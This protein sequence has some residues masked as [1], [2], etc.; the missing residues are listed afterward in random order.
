MQL[1]YTLRRRLLQPATEQTHAMRHPTF[2]QPTSE[3][4]PNPEALPEALP[5]PTGWL[6][7][8]GSLLPLLL[9][10]ISLV[11]L[12]IC[13]VHA[14]RTRQDAWWFFIILFMP[15]FGPL[16]YLLAVL[17][18]SWKG[19]RVFTSA[20]KRTSSSYRREIKNLELR[21][22]QVDTV[23]TRSELGDACLKAG[24]F[25]KA[26]EYFLSCLQGNY[27]TNPYFWY[28]LAQ[29]C[30]EL[31]LYDEALNAI[32]KTMQA[33]YTDYKNDRV[34]LKAKTLAE[35]NRDEEAISLFQEVANFIPTQEGLCRLGIIL[36]R[37]NR[38][39]EAKQVFQKIL[40]SS[41]AMTPKTRKREKQWIDTAKKQL[42][43][44]A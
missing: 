26:R 35:L 19:E 22:S 12:V 20:A 5:E 28:G 42:Q 29:A 33:N 17:L 32:D 2:Y 8:V 9:S 13:L 11:L 21:L 37:N 14:I 43:K 34:L 1:F 38:T 31:G 16:V 41:Q 44:H 36:E 7:T 23:A 24:D 4:P 6:Y 15:T 40:R 18:P 39:E 25:A 10:I 27:R 30:Y 3:P